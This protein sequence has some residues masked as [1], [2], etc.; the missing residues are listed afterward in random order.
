MVAV[1][2]QLRAEIAT[3]KR[4]VVYPVYGGDR[5]QPVDE[6]LLYHGQMR[7]WDT[8]EDL[9][10]DPHIWAV[11][12]KRWNAVVCREWE[13]KPASNSAPDK[14]AADIVR[15]NLEA[16]ATRTPTEEKGEAIVTTAGGFDQTSLGL[17]DAILKGF[18]VGEIIWGADGKENF[19]DEIRIK[20]QRRFT[21]V[22]GDRGYKLK[23]LTTEQPFNGITLPARKFIVHTF[24]GY[25]S[26]YGF[27]LGAKLFWPKFF[28]SNDI[29]FWLAFCDKY[30]SP[31]AVAT[32]PDGRDD[33]RDELL[34]MID[35]IAQ[36]TGIAI[37]DGTA[38][39]FLEATRSSTINCYKDLADYMDR[40]VSKAV[41][42]E[43]GSTDQTGGD[44]GSRARDQV[45]N[46]VRIEIAKGDAD[47]LSD[48]LNRTLAKWLTEYNVPD[49][50]P[51]KIWRK[52]PELEASEDLGAR[53]TRDETIVRFMELKPST[54]YIKDT[55][56][57]ELIEPEPEP[58]QP[59]TLDK[60]GS[61]F[62]GG[63]QP[64]AIPDGGAA[65]APA[66]DASPEA[67]TPTPNTADLSEPIDFRG[68][69]G[70]AAK[71]RTC[72][73]G[74]GCGDTCISRAKQCRKDLEAEALE[75][76]R[77]LAR[78]SIKLQL[79]KE[80]LQ[81]QLAEM[82]A[83]L[84]EVE[85]QALATPE[86][87][88]VL[89]VPIES[90]NF[91]PERFQYKLV[92]GAT[93][94]SGSLSGVKTWDANLAGLVQVWRDPADGKTYVVNGHNR[95]NLAKQLGVDN[96][97]VRYLD[98]KDAREARVTGAITNVAEG[99]GTA[100]DAAKFFKD[101]GLTREDLQRKGIP[102]REAIATHGLALSEL[103]DA[104]FRRVIDGDMPQ[105]RAVIIGGSGLKKDEQ[106]SLVDLI[107]Q[108]EKK[109]RRITNEVISELTDV[110]KSSG[111]QSEQQFD[112]FGMTETTRNL[113]LEK[114]TLQANIRKKL[115]REKKL[116][117]TVAKSRAAKDL[118]KAGNQIDIER[119]KGVSD[120]AAQTLAVFDQLKNLS[121]PVSSLINQAAER[122]ANG[123]KADR[124]TDDLYQKMVSSLPD[125]LSGKTVEFAEFMQGAIDFARLK[126]AGNTQQAKN[127]KKGWPC[128]F[129]CL[130]RA[131]KNCKKPIEGQAKAYVDWL[132]RKI[133][134]TP[135]NSLSQLDKG[136]AIAN[137]LLPSDK[138]SDKPKTRADGTL[139]AVLEIEDRLR[140][141]RFETLVAFDA[142]GNQVFSR[143]GDKDSVDLENAETVLSLKGMVVTHNHPL[144]WNYQE[145]EPGHKGNSFSKDDWNLFAYGEM[146]E[147]RAVSIGYR[148]SIK[149][150]ENG[151]GSGEPMDRVDR[152]DNAWRQAKREVDVISHMS[153]D[154][155]YALGQAQGERAVAAANAEFHHEMAVRVAKKLGLTYIREPYEPVST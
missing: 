105:E 89:D 122:V 106:R 99:R 138:P 97:T 67:D 76:Q 144:G 132:E 16:L 45:G 114:A 108:Q 150:P 103:D 61:I 154:L 56:G 47:L 72:T 63:A 95:A 137:R 149:A 29:K 100:I 82:Q 79:D 88:S 30:G 52:F 70:K 65:N 58:Q 118:A 133:Q 94:S 74:F 124:V 71:R 128:G 153:I 22:A 85:A 151:W 8:Y 84:A 17:L 68:D 11:M 3:A 115:S 136:E 130:S 19:I 43:T 27:G 139:M 57:I 91:D 42:G 66:A 81:R 101:S 28:K 46:D 145:G 53:A 31:T 110:V 21:Y 127:C 116:F 38:L 24:Q 90:L 34:K 62:G 102:M 39:S 33:L 87:G 36:E 107:E 35:R 69:P 120:Q 23:L 14:K 9:L 113:A 152:L 119:S 64:A 55:Y 131:K 80:E 15:A 77:Y 37:P 93:G 134:L 126:N 140:P 146:A 48:T 129:T 117:S 13:V 86:P 78:Q 5:L 123:E 1:P 121:G 4:D 109:G 112:L 73:K 147:M 49:A 6:L 125:I 75:A 155:G 10:L 59:S 20:N 148:H 83:K 104:L 7:Q 25:K 51:P 12:Q 41:L 96:V 143:E 26:P 50:T 18:A 40:E 98:V 92:H 44:G 141:N 142:D 111:S 54:K 135:G 2:R 60:L 32:Y